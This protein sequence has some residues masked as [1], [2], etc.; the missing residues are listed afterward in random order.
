MYWRLSSFY[1]FYFA[2]LGALWPY[3]GPYLKGRGFVE[4]DIGELVA[5]VMV[6]KVVAPY[7]WGWVADHSGQRMKIVRL[8]SLLATLT[9][10]GIFFGNG[11]LW[12]ALVMLVYSFF[13]NASLPQFEAT[14]M[15]HLGDDTQRYSSIR[16]WGSIGFII[17][18]AGLGPAIN[19]YGTDIVPWVFLLLLG[20][21][22]VASLLV[23]E[24]A[25]GHLPL[26]HEP[27]HNVLRQPAVIGLFVVCFLLQ[28]SHGTYYTFYSIYLQDFDYDYSVIGGLWAL[29]VLAEIVVFVY[30]P[31]L[32]PRYGE[33][34]LMVAS[35]GLA[36]LR[37][38][39]IGFGVE[40]PVVLVL[41]QLLH[42]ASFG[43][44]HAVAIS[45]IHHYFT[46]RHQGRGQ[47]LYSSVS[48]GAGGATGSIISGYL[49]SDIGA[50]ATFAIAAGMSAVAAFIAWRS[51]PQST[52]SAG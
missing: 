18:V 2:A 34:V 22:W 46:G 32:L 21:I 36:S 23:P 28:A 7:I 20:G 19:R 51:L 3:W 37:W 24:Q 26:G 15:T 12:L 5:I 40:N 35:L 1:L 25:A 39:M 42:A 10:T 31:R 29:G 27:I 6:T 41:A 33:R 38:L 9:F 50:A 17:A 52:P 44:Y 49:W 16:L 45:L 30:M 14:T 8:A 47:A 11:Y 13:W 43:V 4:S 48:F